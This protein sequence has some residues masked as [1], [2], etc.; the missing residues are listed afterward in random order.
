[1]EE[2]I[3]QWE[4]ANKRYKAAIEEEKMTVTK[5]T[6][7]MFERFRW[8]QDERLL[9]AT[10]GLPDE[11]VRDLILGNLNLSARKYE[12]PNCEKFLKDANIFCPSAQYAFIIQEAVQRCI[13]LDKYN[14]FRHHNPSHEKIDI[15]TF[16]LIPQFYQAG[17][18][19]RKT[20]FDAFMTQWS[21]MHIPG[22]SYHGADAKTLLR[23]KRLRV[24]TL[25]KV[26]P[27]DLLLLIESF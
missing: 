1:M 26:F 2:L 11:L 17:N 27:E 4:H 25:I 5:I 12:N 14:F 18:D 6:D 21:R 20:T 3:G 22:P 10:Q 24:I 16:K 8:Y 15:E 9:N 19:I 7:S 13:L 23:F